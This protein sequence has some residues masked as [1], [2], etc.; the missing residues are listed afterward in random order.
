[1]SSF[2]HYNQDSGFGSLSKRAED[3]QSE[4][5][6]TIGGNMGNDNSSTLQQQLQ[7]S[8]GN[9]LHSNRI[10]NLSTYGTTSLQLTQN[11]IFNKQNNRFNIITMQP[12]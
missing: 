11:E 10:S 9:S 4:R 3:Y 6:H 1:M 12:K 5:Y 7:Q 8:R 2:S